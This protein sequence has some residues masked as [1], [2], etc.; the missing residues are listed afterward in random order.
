[1]F[2]LR[3]HYSY[4]YSMAASVEGFKKEAV[5]YGEEIAATVFTE[6]TFNPADKLDHKELENH[7]PPN[8]ILDR[9]LQ[10]LQREEPE[11]K[12]S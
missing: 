1:M 2:K 5:K 7:R 3:E 8:P 4:K 12:T 6:L 11:A 10:M 9:L